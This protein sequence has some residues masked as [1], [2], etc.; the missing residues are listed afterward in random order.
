LL[1]VTKPG[2]DYAQFIKNNITLIKDVSKIA[3]INM[4][5]PI[6][7]EEQ[8]SRIIGPIELSGSPSSNY[9]LKLLQSDAGIGEYAAI[10]KV[11][12]GALNEISKIGDKKIKVL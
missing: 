2:T 6:R 7:P 3:F 4:M 9:D 10:V 1:N 8:T 11:E 12:D 5:V